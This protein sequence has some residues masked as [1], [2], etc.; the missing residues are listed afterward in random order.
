[1]LHIRQSADRNVQPAATLFCS[2]HRNIEQ[3]KRDVKLLQRDGDQLRCAVTRDVDEIRK[4]VEQFKRDVRR[5]VN[6]EIT[7]V[8]EKLH[9][10]IQGLKRDVTEL[11]EMQQADVGASTQS[12]NTS[13]SG[14]VSV[15][16]MLP[17]EQP[18]RVL[19]CFQPNYR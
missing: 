18:P 5:E 11:R 6:C 13:C 1:M 14:I 12:H 15:M 9:T 4:E 16:L 8:R 7:E 3:L 2:L 10:D 19:Y 17:R